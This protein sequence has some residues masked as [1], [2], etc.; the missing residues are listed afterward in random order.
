MSHL[1]TRSAGLALAAAAAFLT[2]CG[3]P[4]QNVI[5]KYF[6]ALRQNDN[7]TLASFALVT[8]DKKVDKYTVKSTVAENKEAAPL[9]ALAAK[10]KEAETQ[11]NANKKEYNAYNLDHLTEV[12][13]LRELKKS[14]GKIPPKLATTAADW[15]KFEQKERELKKQLADAK[16]AVAREK[17]NMMVSIG[18]VDDV[19]GL[20]GE[21]INKQVELELVIAGQPE[22]YVMTLRKYDVKTPGGKGPKVI[23]RW[24][25]AG[26]QKA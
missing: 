21:V 4:E 19:E 20:E 6:Q 1:P 7:Q 2:A 25:V 3:H 15:D 8:F 22:K 24:V 5:D 16:N 26:L 13:E 18:N 14:G 11:Y 9:T 12:T 23:S 10:Q 17:A